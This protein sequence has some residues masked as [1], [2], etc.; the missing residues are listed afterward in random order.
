MSTHKYITTTTPKNE[1]TSKHNTTINLSA[2][3][4]TDYKIVDDDLFSLST[5]L[6]QDINLVEAAAL[7]KNILLSSSSNAAMA[8]WFNFVS[9]SLQINIFLL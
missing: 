4:T 6:S 3:P 5:L 2:L 8:I 9:G 1:D 7:V